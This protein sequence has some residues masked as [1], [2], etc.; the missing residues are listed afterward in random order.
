MDSRAPTYLFNSLATLGLTLLSITL[1]AAAFSR[2]THRSKTW[3][4]M[5]VSWQVYAASYLLI[6]GYQ[7]GPEPSR[8]ICALQTM[9]IYSTPPLTTTTGLAFIFDTHLRLTKALFANK[10]IHKHT[11][12]L[13]IAPWALFVAVAAGGLIAVRDFAEVQRDPNHMYCHSVINTQTQ[14]SAIICVIGLSTA[15]I[16]ICE[17]SHFLSGSNADRAQVW[18][19]IIL[20]RNWRLFRQIS[21]SSAS[22]LRLSSLVR[23]LV[24]TIQTSIGIGLG[25]FEAKGPLKSGLAI[26]SALLPILPVLCGIAFGTQ[27]DIVRC[28][29]FWKSSNEEPGRKC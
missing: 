6:L 11:L 7:L 12:F 5:I 1:L 14:I 28:L 19:S 26:W 8:G 20:Y 16:L 21:V 27:R 9:L 22:D 10:T 23:I 29:M 18:T 17:H 15:L 3:Y 13:L 24:F 4:S 25:A 2:H